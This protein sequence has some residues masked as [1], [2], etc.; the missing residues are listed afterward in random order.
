[1]G[2]EETGAA[3]EFRIQSLIM[4]AGIVSAC[5]SLSLFP[6]DVL[7]EEARWSGVTASEREAGSGEGCTGEEEMVVGELTESQV[8]S[9]LDTGSLSFSHMDE[10]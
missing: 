7:D 9:S 1:M 4:V 8:N 10:W 3:N 2:Y 5:Y 6:V